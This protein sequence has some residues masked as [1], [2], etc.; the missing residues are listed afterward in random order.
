MAT[1]VQ[2]LALGRPDVGFFLRSDGRGALALPATADLRERVSQVHGLSLARGLVALEDP[3]VWGLVSPLEMSF[4]TRRHLHVAVNGRV[5]DADSFAPAIARAYA[6]LLPKGRHP[7][8]FL[9]LDLGP[10]EV[11]VNVHPAKSAVR[12]RGGRS[13]YPLVVGAIRAAI[14]PERGPGSGVPEEEGGTDLVPIGQFAGRCIVAQEG[15]ALIILD[16]H[17]AHERILYE[18]LRENPEAPPAALERPVTAVLPEDLAPEA[19]AFEEDL[20][21]LGFL[22]EPFGPDAVRVT[23]APATA[24][25]PEA[26]F[27][28]ALHA[29]AGG[30]DLAK[31]LACKGS[32]KFGEDLSREGM[33]AL[34][35]EWASCE[36]PNVCPH[37]RP[38]VKRVALADLLREF[39]R[40]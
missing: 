29:L 4:P 5:V 16:Q 31:A 6:D 25:D 17:G 12:L 23:A 28:A 9:R 22:F 18:R 35:D 20:G 10:G 1:V 27:L 13:A 34:L 37:G 19:W 33:A 11:D 3:V 40:L 15:E 32:T 39:G 36:F 14:S 7:A 30:D 8:A 24:V 2:A 38:I 26:A 21:S